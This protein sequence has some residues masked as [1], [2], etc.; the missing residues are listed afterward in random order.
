MLWGFGISG[1]ML[2]WMVVSSLLIAGAITAGSVFLLRWRQDRR[3]RAEYHAFEILAARY[4][5]GEIDQETFTAM[6]AN[7]LVER[8]G[9]R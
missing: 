5:R 9:A 2:L 4:A 6:R 1:A 3:R 8:A 7:L